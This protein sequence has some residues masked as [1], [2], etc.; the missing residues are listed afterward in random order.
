MARQLFGY[1]LLY[2]LKGLTVNGTTNIKTLW[3]TLMKKAK[4]NVKTKMLK[5]D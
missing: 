5:A 3:L 1:L 4:K 2:Y